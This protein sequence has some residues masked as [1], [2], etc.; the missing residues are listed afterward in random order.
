LDCSPSAF[1]LFLV[2]CATF[3][4]ASMARVSDFIIGIVYYLHGGVIA[5]LSFVSCPGYHTEDS[6]SIGVRCETVS[7]TSRRSQPPLALAVPL[8]RFASQVGGGSAFFVRQLRAYD[9]LLR[10]L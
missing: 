8:S 10:Q 2:R 3:C 6:A 7:L 9:I 1:G 5:D 4:F